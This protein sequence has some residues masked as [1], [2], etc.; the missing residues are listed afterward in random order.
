[1]SSLFLLY[2]ARFPSYFSRHTNTAGDSEWDSRWQVYV[3]AGRFLY[4][5]VVVPL[6]HILPSVYLVLRNIW[7]CQEVLL[8]KESSFLFWRCSVET[9]SVEMLW[10]HPRPQKLLWYRMAIFT[11]TSNGRYSTVWSLTENFCGLW[12]TS[13]LFPIALL[14]RWI[15]KVD[16]LFLGRKRPWC[17]LW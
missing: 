11:C 8:R 4:T 17:I 5:C 13:I 15:L 3:L 12:E 10:D 16:K 7:L 1:M 14:R 6:S 9:A 2:L